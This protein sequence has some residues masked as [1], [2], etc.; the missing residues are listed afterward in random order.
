MEEKEMSEDIYQVEIEPPQ[1]FDIYEHPQTGR[2]IQIPKGTEPTKHLLDSLSKEQ[3]EIKKEES[4]REK[5]KENLK[6]TEVLFP[7]TASFIKRKGLDVGSKW[8]QIKKGVQNIPGGMATMAMDASTGLFRGPGAVASEVES[9]IKGQ[10]TTVLEQMDYMNKGLD[11]TGKPKEGVSKFLGGVATDPATLPSLATGS[12][13]A[14][15][16]YKGGKWL[17]TLAK[18]MATGATEGAVSAGVHQSDRA[19]QG[20]DVSLKDAGKEVLMSAAVPVAVGLP[21]KGANKLLGG[22]ASSLSNVS[23][24]TLRKWGTGFGK[25][26]KELKQ[27][28]GTQ[29][30]I[31]KK[32]L[33]ALDDYDQFIPERQA[34]DEVLASMPDMP[35]SNTLKTIQKTI[36]DFP[37]KKTNKSQIDKLKDLLIDAKSKGESLSASDFK[38]FRGEIDDIVEWGKTGSKKLNSALVDIRTSMKKELIG[39]AESSGK[40]QYKEIM[41]SW[42]DKMQKRDALLEEIGAN[43]KTRNKRIGVFMSTLFNK[44]KE[45]RQK[46]LSDMSEIFGEDF[47]EQAKLLQ[48]SDAMMQKGGGFS[49]IL[50]NYETG[51]ASTSFIPAAMAGGASRYL[52]DPKALA[53]ALLLAAEASPMASSKVLTVAELAEWMSKQPAQLGARQQSK[54]EK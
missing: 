25:G 12:S 40:P 38:K 47:V 52:D 51:R 15:W 34:I 2:E 16:A 32:I 27:I 45:T 21:A 53:G 23:E 39:T 4:H 8:E 7:R 1:E 20:E 17:P 28:H 33:T 14:N 9:E 43:A 13:M 37:L 5:V 22:L 19:L 10:P 30:Q 35:M 41:E 6:A 54:E 24:E 29:Q 49:K 36:D 48:M 31:G 11:P 18:S 3:D 46:A 50:P 44:N 42:A 26:A